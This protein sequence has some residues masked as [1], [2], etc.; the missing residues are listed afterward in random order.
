MKI[1]VQ[2]N[3]AAW[4]A[5]GGAVPLLHRHRA[6][7]GVRRYGHGTSKATLRRGG[8]TVKQLPPISEQ[9]SSNLAAA[10]IDTARIPAKPYW[11]LFCNPSIW[12]AER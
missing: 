3:P 12:L 4:R 9:R 8:K 2:V 5:D 7:P 10:F 1:Q 11:Y 6:A